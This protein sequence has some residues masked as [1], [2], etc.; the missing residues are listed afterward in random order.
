MNT[1]TA[2]SLELLIG[3]GYFALAIAV[4]VGLMKFLGHK[5]LSTAGTIFLIGFP[6]IGIIGGT[7]EWLFTGVAE[8]SKSVTFNMADKCFGIAL[9]LYTL[10]FFSYLMFGEE[11]KQNSVVNKRVK[12]K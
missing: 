10:A 9:A 8:A 11:E 4:C 5:I 7:I 2:R 1:I 3:L 6:A 12:A